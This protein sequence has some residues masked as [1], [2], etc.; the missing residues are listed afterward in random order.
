MRFYL[1][2]Y[3]IWKP[4]MCAHGYKFLIFYIFITKDHQTKWHIY[5]DCDSFNHASWFLLRK[6][7]HFESHFFQTFAKFVDMWLQVC[8]LVFVYKRRIFGQIST[9]FCESSPTYWLLQLSW[10]RDPDPY[11]SKWPTNQIRSNIRLC[12][13][14]FG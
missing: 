14:V 7:S 10:L 11:Y 5:L 2:K 9:I 3:L 6:I 8:V 12:L 13:M 1:Q 4:C